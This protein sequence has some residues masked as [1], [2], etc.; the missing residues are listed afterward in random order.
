MREGGAVVR[1]DSWTAWPVYW[2]PVICGALASI[3][4]VVLGVIATAMGSWKAGHAQPV[5]PNGAKA[6][7]AG[8]AA[9][10]IL[11]GLVGS[12]GGGGMGSGERIGL[13]LLASASASA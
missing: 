8:A 11:L 10:A 1:A 13:Q 9:A 6:A 7:A 12:G 3:V 2:T 4:A 5:D